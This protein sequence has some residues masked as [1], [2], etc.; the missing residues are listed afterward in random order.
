MYITVNY[1]SDACNL[2]SSESDKY[3]IYKLI[4]HSLFYLVLSF[5]YLHEN[6]KKYDY[7]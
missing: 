1:A 2:L 5:L 3:T 4:A 7:M 6:R